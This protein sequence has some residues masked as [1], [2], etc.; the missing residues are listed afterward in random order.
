LRQYPDE[1]LHATGAAV[2]QH[3]AD[4]PQAIS[5]DYREFLSWAYYARLRDSEEHYVEPFDQ[6]RRRSLNLTYYA[7]GDTRQRRIAI[8]TIDEQLRSLGF[9]FDENDELPYHLCVVLE[10]LGLSE[11]SSHEQAVEFVASYRDGL[12]VLRAA[13]EH[14]DSP[15]VS[16]FIAVCR[17]LPRVDAEIAQKYVDLIRTGPP[18]EVVGIADLPFPTVQPD[19]L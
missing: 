6:R 19:D 8:M 15:Y 14:T 10:A 16:L 3:V 7:V 5:E 18:A 11:G 12:E 2:E 17:A 9:D 4:L 1:R 13:L